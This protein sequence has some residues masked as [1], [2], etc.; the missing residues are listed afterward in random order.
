MRDVLGNDIQMRQATRGI[1]GRAPSDA[2][3]DTC[4]VLTK[5]APVKTLAGRGTA[6]AEKKL[7]KCLRLGKNVPAKVTNQQIWLGIPQ[8]LQ[9]GAVHL[10][11]VAIGR[12]PANRVGRILN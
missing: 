10:Q 5:P 2:Y 11:Q 1:A 9:H 4:S 8:H 7:V 12:T 3:A 6:E